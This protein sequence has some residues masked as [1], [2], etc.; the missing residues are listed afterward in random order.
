MEEV[1]LNIFLQTAVV[2]FIKNYWGVDTYQGEKLLLQLF[3]FMWLKAG[4]PFSSTIFMTRYEVQPELQRCGENHTEC[5]GGRTDG[6]RFCLSFW[7]VLLCCVWMWLEPFR[8]VPL[9]CFV[10]SCL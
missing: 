4:N 5:T 10:P 3:K 8:R 7:L 6:C 2:W 1:I 9:V